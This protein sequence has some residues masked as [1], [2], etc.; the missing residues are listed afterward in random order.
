MLTLSYNPFDKHFDNP[1]D[2]FNSVDLVSLRNVAEGWYI[3]YK[4]SAVE[5]R[6]I[7]KS[8]SAFSNHYG[9]W[10]FYGVKESEDGTHQAGTFPGI[11][12]SDA[13]KLMENIKNAVKDII[14][15]SPYFEHRLIQGPCDE[16]GLQ[17]GKDIVVVG[18]PIGLD[19]PYIHNDG[20]IYR[21]IADSSDPKHETDKSI[22]D[23]LW[24]RRR[25][26]MEKLSSFLKES[27]IP[28]DEEKKVPYINIFFLPDPLGY[29]SQT[30]K[31][32]FKEF[33]DFLRKPP[34]TKLG[35]SISFDNFF[36]M[37]NGMIARHIYDNDASCLTLTWKFYNN[38]FSIISIPFSDIAANEISL[39]GWLKG[40]EQEI[41][42]I[43]LLTKWK[44]EK[45]HIIDINDIFQLIMVILEQNRLLLEKSKIQGQ[46]YAKVVFHNLQGRIPFIDTKLFINFIQQYGMPV[47]QFEKE[48]SLAKNV[49]ETLVQLGDIENIGEN[50]RQEM[51]PKDF[52]KLFENIIRGLGLPLSGLIDLDSD[53]SIE[54]VISLFEAARR[55]SEVGKRRRI[56]S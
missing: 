27:I 34:E 17:D 12:H 22:L 4:E 51:I 42:F 13:V 21:R 50:K 19:S 7:A 26:S 44:F 14:I 24:N 52:I 8:I 2:E 31:L 1:F 38:G 56:A 41:F 53:D 45:N 48:Y 40:Y 20:R 43:D 55:A 11:N 16:I 28:S 6:K 33:V 5:P 3:E 18:V 10:I 47:L 49:F 35:F 30:V 32:K 37:E 54:A 23:N 29:A 9:G 46:Y 39:N 36:T 25:Q 15:P